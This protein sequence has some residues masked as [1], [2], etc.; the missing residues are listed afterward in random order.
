[1]TPLDSCGHSASERHT[2]FQNFEMS[3]FDPFD[4]TLN[5]ISIFNDKIRFK[6]ILTVCFEFY[7]KI[8]T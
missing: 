7:V 5:F 3:K 4:L 2:S 1:M 8:R 6:G